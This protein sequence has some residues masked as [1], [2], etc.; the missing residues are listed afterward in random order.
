MSDRRFGFYSLVLGSILFIGGLYIIIITFI[1]HWS[2][3]NPTELLLFVG[4]ALLL[5]GIILI[6]YGVKILRDPPEIYRI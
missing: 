5:V 4:G 6:L 1:F 3:F 2:A